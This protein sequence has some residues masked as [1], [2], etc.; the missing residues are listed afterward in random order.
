MVQ[1]TLQRATIH[2]TT[3]HEFWRYAIGVRTARRQWALRSGTGLDEVAMIATAAQVREVLLDGPKSVRDLDGL[4]EGFVGVAG[5]WIDLVRVPPSGTWE[6]RRADRLG[7][8][9][10]WVG[11]CDATEEEGSAHLIRAYL[12]GY[13]PAAW[14]DIAQWAGVQVR[15]LRRVEEAVD[16]VR[17]RDE[18]GRELIDL[19]DQPLPDPDTPAPVRFLPH[20]DA[21]VLVHARRT[22]ILAEEYRAR[23]FTSKNPF[24]VGVVLVDGRVVAAWS[25]RDGRIVL[26]PY[27]AIAPRDRDAIEQERAALEAFHG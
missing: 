14:K 9:E 22:A 17:F 18:Q 10:T 27:E 2:L 15:D 5:L 12:R 23:I 19:P 4:V 25:L 26:D 20:W 1:A 21:N 6:R 16:L 7:L 13:G 8:A 11:P 3:R 24:S